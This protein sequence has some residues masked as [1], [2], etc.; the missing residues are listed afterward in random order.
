VL[1]LVNLLFI[2]SDCDIDSNRCGQHRKRFAES[3][4]PMW[5]MMLNSNSASLNPPRVRGYQIPPFVG[6]RS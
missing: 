5:M 1:Q 6:N 3:E 4:K 2:L